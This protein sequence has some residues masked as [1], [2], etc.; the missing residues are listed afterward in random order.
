MIS[1]AHQAVPQLMSLLPR[2]FVQWDYRNET[3][4][5]FSIFLLR[6]FLVFS[7]YLCVLVGVCPRRLEKGIGIPGV[8]VPGSCEPPE[9]GAGNQTGFRVP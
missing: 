5:P 9:I 3:G 4:L 2:P 6:I 8:G 1:L 7:F